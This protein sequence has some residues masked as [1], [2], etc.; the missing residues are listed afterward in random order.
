MKTCKNVALA[1]FFFCVLLTPAFVHA[2]IYVQPVELY[3]FKLPY[4]SNG[5]Y[6]TPYYSQG[7]G[8]GY[9][10]QGVVG[11][12]Y[13]PPPNNFPVAYNVIVP[14]HQWVVHQGSRTYYYYQSTYSQ[15]G[16]DY[17]YMG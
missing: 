17:S 16:S 7:V 3:R 2:G 8:N 15:L 12:I 10:Y 1:I 11:S 6:L 5:Y 14:V 4:A 13:V 9:I